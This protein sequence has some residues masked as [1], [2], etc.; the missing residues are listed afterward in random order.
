[1]IALHTLRCPGCRRPCVDTQAA[2]RRWPRCSFC[3][4][5]LVHPGFTITQLLRLAG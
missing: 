4:A 1:M 2:T 5:D 3:D